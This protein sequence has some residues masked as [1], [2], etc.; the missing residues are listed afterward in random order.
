MPRGIYE[1][2]ASR[3]APRTAPTSTNES[4]NVLAVIENKREKF[5][6]IA[7]QRFNILKADFRRMGRLG[8]PSYDRTPEEV[9][10]LVARLTKE[11]DFMVGQL[12][13]SAET[14]EDEGLFD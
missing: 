9:E 14:D 4:G 10:K 3:N 11:F 8:G 7:Q 2:K 1:R 12:R 13:H 6:R 5:R